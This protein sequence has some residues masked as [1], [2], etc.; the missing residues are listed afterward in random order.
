[1]SQYVRPG[2]TT[3]TYVNDI[4]SITTPTGTTSFG[5]TSVTPAEIVVPEL[6]YAHTQGVSNATWTINHNLDFYPNVT[7]VDSA[8]TIVEGEIAYTSR[9]QVVLTFSAAF[10]GKAY[11]S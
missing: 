11:L 3:T 6:A 9:N 1:M 7:V 5:G 2:S 10:S 4:I 8:G